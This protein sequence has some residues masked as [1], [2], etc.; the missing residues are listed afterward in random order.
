MHRLPV[1]FRRVNPVGTPKAVRT[2]DGRIASVK[3]NPE[4]VRLIKWW[5]LVF[6]CVMG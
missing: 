1:S 2:V 4:F 3:K 6:Q 5:R